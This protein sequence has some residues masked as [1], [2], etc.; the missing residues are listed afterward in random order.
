[1][2]ELR[3]IKRELSKKTIKMT[4][5]EMKKWLDEGKKKWD[6]DIKKLGLGESKIN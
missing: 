6:E 2:N 1:M 5:P 4:W 3:K